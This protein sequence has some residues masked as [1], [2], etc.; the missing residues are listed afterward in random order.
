[1]DVKAKLEQYRKALLYA[2]K[3]FLELDAVTALK[4]PGMSG[5]PRGSD[6][7]DN[8][9]RMAIRV[10]ASKERAEKA[11]A[12]VLKEMDEIEAM[13][14]SLE[15]NEQKAVL[16]L[17]YIKGYTWEEVATRLYRSTATIYRIHGSALQELR[18]R[19]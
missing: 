16:R 6:R 5:M 7:G 14:E 1:M 11:R 9:E 17:R 18:R 8:L 13:I 15:D 12:K 4:S 19:A 3:C 2:E 10:I